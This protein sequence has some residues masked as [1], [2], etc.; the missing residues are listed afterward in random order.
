[1]MACAGGSTI[2]AVTD[3]YATNCNPTACPQALTACAG[4]M[5]CDVTLSNGVCQGDPCVNTQKT[6]SV[7]ITCN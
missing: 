3:V 2:T 6:W 5:S 4:N 7:T 1:M